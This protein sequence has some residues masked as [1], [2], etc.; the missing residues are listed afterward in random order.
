MQ[1]ALGIDYMQHVLIPGLH[2][3]DECKNRAVGRIGSVWLSHWILSSGHSLTVL[4]SS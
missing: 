3:E 2:K 1:A 4:M